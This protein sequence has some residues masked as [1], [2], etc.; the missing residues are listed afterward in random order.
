MISQLQIKSCHRTVNSIKK[1]FTMKGVGQV[2][3]QPPPLQIYTY[4]RSSVAINNKVV[5]KMIDLDF[6]CLHM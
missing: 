4:L 3:D 2:Q 5:R 6:I 1:D